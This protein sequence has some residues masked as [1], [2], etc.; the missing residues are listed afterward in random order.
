MEPYVINYGAYTRFAEIRLIDSK[1]VYHNAIHIK[2]A[3]DIARESKLELVCFSEPTKDQLALCKIVDYGKWKYHNDKLL[4][5][6]EQ[7]KTV[8]KEVQLSPVISDH[9][10]AHKAKKTIEF[11][12]DGNEVIVDMRFKGI[13]HRLVSEGER[14]INLMISMCKDSGK[15]VYRKKSNDNISVRLTRN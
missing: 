2:K 15:E 1:E 14:I 13:H 3:K 6:K 12:K 9:D 4:K 10:L 8:T 11:L 5:K 7:H